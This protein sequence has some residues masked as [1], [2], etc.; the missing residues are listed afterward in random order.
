MK[1]VLTISGSDPVSGAGLQADLKTFAA[2]DVYGL[3]VVTSVTAQNCRAFFCSHDISH[4]FVGAQVD[5][6]IAQCVP[7]AVKIG[8]LSNRDVAEEVGRKI[9]QYDLKN[10]FLDPVMIAGSGGH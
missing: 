8:M 6:V 2:F 7:D 3:C 9:N 4:Q 5:S 10:I 1:T